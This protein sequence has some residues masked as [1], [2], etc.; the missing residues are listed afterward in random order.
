MTPGGF[1][2]WSCKV[3]RAFRL[4]KEKRCTWA[5]HLLGQERCNA[6]WMHRHVIWVDICN[7]VLPL[8]DKKAK[9]QTLARKGP[10]G[11]I[12]DD[13]KMASRNLKGDASVLKQNPWD[14]ARVY[15]FPV[16]GGRP[17]ANGR[18]SRRLGAAAP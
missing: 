14:G 15:W 17:A 18:P 16:R 12:S 7:G 11:W 3:V 10:K 13:A 4:M 5:T 8:S 1:P 2:S 9:E 6:A